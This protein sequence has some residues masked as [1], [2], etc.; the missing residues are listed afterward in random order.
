M[1]YNIDYESCGSI[2][3]VLVIFKSLPDLAKNVLWQLVQLRGGEG[4]IISW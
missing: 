2:G 1:F 3:R 4:A